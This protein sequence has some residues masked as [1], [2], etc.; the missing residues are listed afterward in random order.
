MP[1]QRNLNGTDYTAISVTGN[2]YAQFFDTWHVR[3]SMDPLAESYCN[4]SPY[5]FC[6]NNPK[7]FI[8]LEK[9][10][11]NRNIGITLILMI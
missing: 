3:D 4:T 11:E 1:R 8:L 7:Q 10:T 5:V 2:A 6:N 9:L